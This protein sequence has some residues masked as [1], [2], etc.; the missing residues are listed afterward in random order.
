[1]RDRRGGMNAWSHRRSSGSLKLL[2]YSSVYDQPDLGAA[3]I[4]LTNQKELSLCR[5]RDEGGFL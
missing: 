5:C 1:M 2:L 4:K 3:H